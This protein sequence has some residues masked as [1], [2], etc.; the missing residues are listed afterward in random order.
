MSDIFDQ[1]INRWHTWEVIRFKL[2]A[3]GFTDRA[4]CGADDSRQ[5]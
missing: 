5:L 4:C 3:D 1:E 2:R